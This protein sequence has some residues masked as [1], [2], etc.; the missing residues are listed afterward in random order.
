MK[1]IIKKIRKG[2]RNP[3]LF[4]LYFL[5]TKISRIF[6]DKLQ[7]SLLYRLRIGKRIDWKN[8]QGFNEKLQWLKIN[9]RNPAYV[10]LVDKF[11]VRSF[12]SD[13]IGNQYLVKLFGVYDNP[14]EI[15]FSALPN[16]F[17]LK[18]THTS[19]NVIICRDKTE[20]DWN[21]TI[22]TLSKW[23]KR[24]YFW[25]QRE[26]PYKQIIPRIICEE[27]LVDSEMDELI[28]YKIL[29]FHGEPQ[30]LFLALD[31]GSSSGL[32]VDFYDLQWNP[33]PFERHYPRSGR[34]IEKPACFTE[35]L[36]LSRELAR[37]IPF[38]RVDF[39]VVNGKIKFGE[40]TFYPGSG[41]EEFTP[42]EYDKKLGDLINLDLVTRKTHD[43]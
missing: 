30:C 37:G 10:Q 20:L 12:I 21:E 9:D 16:Q 25:Y 23:L 32:K 42:E 22:K 36:E 28:D 6:S 27:L 34:K 38:V 35:M 7:I 5:G 33:L 26:W 29:C 24:E 11:A 39:Y 3:K 31:R 17:V 1:K 41:L 8:P 19:G 13:R 43:K 4:G 14:N 18:P 15:D 40:L 2:F